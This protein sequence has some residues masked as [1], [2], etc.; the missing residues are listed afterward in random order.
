MAKPCRYRQPGTDAWLSE[1]DF[2]KTLNDGLLDKYINDDIISIRGFKPKTETAPVEEAPATKVEEVKVETPVAEAKEVKI[3]KNKK[4]RQEA[5]DKD[6]MVYHDLFGAVIESTPEQYEAALKEKSETGSIAD[7]MKYGKQISERQ[8]PRSDSFRPSLL[9]YNQQDAQETLDFDKKYKEQKQEDKVELIAETTKVESNSEKISRGAD[10]LN[11]MSEEER[12]NFIDDWFNDRISREELPGGSDAIKLLEARKVAP[13]P[14]SK[15]KRLTIDNAFELSNEHGFIINI[16]GEL[17]GLSKVEDPDATSDAEDRYGDPKQ[18]VW[19]YSKIAEGI[20]GKTTDTYTNDIDEVI[21]DIKSSNKKSEEAPLAEAKPETKVETVAEVKESGYSPTDNIINR[22]ELTKNKTHGWRTMSE[23]EFNSLS[24]GEKTYEGGA[25]KSGNWIAGVPESAAKFSKKGSVMVEFGGINMEGAENMVKGSKADKSNVTKVWRFNNDTKKFEEAPELLDKVR[26]SE[27][28]KVSTSKAKTSDQLRSEADDIFDNQIPSIKG[29]S[30]EFW[31]VVD[32]KNDDFYTSYENSKE[33]LKKEG[34]NLDE[35]LSESDKAKLKQIEQ[36]QQKAEK[37]YD[38][39]DDVESETTTTTEP[40]KAEKAPKAEAKESYKAKAIDKRGG[41]KAYTVTVNNNTA[42]VVGEQRPSPMDPTKM[43]PGASYKGLPITTN[44][45]GQRVVETPTGDTIYLDKPI[46][47]KTEEVTE[48]KE[49]VSEGKGANITVD[50]PGRSVSSPVVKMVKNKRTNQWQA[51]KSD[52]TTY[53]TS[54]TL[55][56]KAEAIYQQTR[57]DAKVVS[58]PALEANT[59]NRQMVFS[60]TTNKWME[61]NGEGILINVTEPSAKAAEK[62]YNTKRE[63]LK[64]KIA[65][66]F[67]S[68]KFNLKGQLNSTPIIQISWNAILELTKKLVLAGADLTFAINDAAKK[69][70]DQMVKE[71]KMTEAEAQEVINYV[72]SDDFRLRPEYSGMKNALASDASKELSAEKIQTMTYK[73]ALDAGEK[74]IESGEINPSEIINQIINVK[75]RSL[76]PI[77]T[78]AMSYY[79]VGLDNELSDLYERLSKETNDDI[80][81]LLINEIDIIEQKISD[82]DV[83]AR[84]TGYFNGLSLALRRVMINSQYDASI[85][86]NKVKAKYGDTKVPEGLEEKLREASNKIKD[87]NKEIERLKKEAE[88]S[89]DSEAVNDIK[90][91]NARRKGKKKTKEEGT[92]VSS[93]DG[94]VAVSTALIREAVEKG[95]TEIEDVVNYVRA[96]VQAMFPDATDRQIRDAISNY[97]KQVNPTQ[98]KIQQEINGIKSVGRMLSKLEDIQ[99]AL[100]NKSAFDNIKSKKARKRARR[101]LSER[102][103]Q[104]KRA[105][106]EEMAKLPLSIEDIEFINEQKLES[107]KKRKQNEI[108]ELDEKILR[109]DLAKKGKQSTIL[110]KEAQE[111]KDKR[112]ALNAELDALR[113]QQPLTDEQIEETRAKR[114]EQYKKRLAD[115]NKDLKRRIAERDFSK[116]PKPES[117]KRDEEARKLEIEREKLIYEY[118]LELEKAE[119]A[120]APTYKKLLRAFA[121]ILNLPKALKAAIDLSAPLRQGIVPLLT[122]SPVKSSKQ[123]WEMM[124]FF[125]NPKSYEAFMDELRSSE[126]YPLLKESGLFIAEQNGKL[127]AMEEMLANNLGNKIPILGSTY[128]LKSGK[129][130]LPGL[131]LYKRSEYAYSGF[132]NNLRVQTF[133][134]GVGALK[135][136]GYTLDANK[137]EFKSWASYVNNATG[138]GTMNANAAMTLGTVFFSPRLIAARM[139]IAMNPFYYSKLSPAARKMAMKKTGAFFAMAATITGLAALWYNNDDDDN[140][141]VELDPRSSDFGKIKIGNSRVDFLGGF[142]PYFRSASQFAMGQKKS[143]TSGQIEELNQKYGSTTRGSIAMDFFANKLAPTTRLGYDWMFK[144]ESE[145]QRDLLEKEQDNSIWNDLGYPVWAQDL[146]VP[147]WTQDIKKLNEEH[148]IGTGLFLT[149]L[150]LYGAGVQNFEPRYKSTSENV[151]LDDLDDFNDFEDVEESEDFDSFDEFEKMK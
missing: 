128:K 19:T 35:L 119:M 32:V 38:K 90:E 54:D 27:K 121:S 24:S 7:I 29:F 102:E 59:R 110:D 48:V 37:L 124:K 129:K 39:A 120:A 82:Y 9:S 68:K 63:D 116:K 51:L 47:E 40:V 62:A 126:Y 4:E 125:A 76:D 79:R 114:L 140:T 100:A 45:N 58:L 85:M 53:E 36:L 133:L 104:L 134:E 20:D 18:Y 13:K 70:T 99:K 105:I 67:D 96:D 25:P 95:A 55:K 77:E 11:K 94:N 137:D 57:T 56:E 41:D 72:S 66:A 91:D 98:D 2:K 97:G 107:Y 118:E 142:L 81:D 17:Y 64:R 130:I 132:L 86:I 103:E 147:I 141:S 148:G 84:I 112:D 144:T 69:V 50:V 113:K 75:G 123:V 93:K 26:K 88:K 30:P 143:L 151:S 5:A 109:N 61:V 74:A 42:D 106:R 111:L 145:K 78:V 43:T 127:N 149:G 136:M 14:M 52:G 87:L 3:P 15:P 92:H 117:I 65:D 146:T 150:N 131:D 21:K 34:T 80:Q 46:A 1:A 83:M 22:P 44:I 122:Q 135:E 60:N 8:A 31:G 23:Q 138:R 108:A 10:M 28:I 89:T 16:D 71:N 139:N 49:R 6:E 12:D 33:R 73:E 115:R 101:Q